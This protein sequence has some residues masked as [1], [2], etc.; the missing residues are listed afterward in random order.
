MNH[1][2]LNQS[3]FE[4]I[5]TQVVDILNSEVKSSKI[6]HKPPMFEE[7]VRTTLKNVLETETGIRQS[8]EIIQGFPDIV[9]EN[10]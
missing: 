4:A 2:Q 5:L 7:L 1:E 8:D 3:Q 6:H 9:C 10:F